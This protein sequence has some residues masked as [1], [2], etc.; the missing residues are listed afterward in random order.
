M[1]AADV[2]NP[3]I[4]P[5]RESVRRIPA[6]LVLAIGVA[7]GVADVWLVLQLWRMVSPP[8][9]AATAG[10]GAW[11]QLISAALFNLAV[12]APL[13]VAAKIGCLVEG[14]RL[15][16]GGGRPAVY[17]GLGLL[18]GAGGFSVA[19][20]LAALAGVVVRGHDSTNGAQAL[21]A[22]TG[23]VLVLGF[24]TVAEEV[25]FRGWLQ[26]VL[27]ARWGAWP[28]L[29]AGAL[30][31]SA[32]HLV[33]GVRSPIAMANLFLGGIL[34]GLLALRSGGLWA[35][36]LAHFGWN[37]LEACGLGLEPN[38]GVGQTGALIN[39]DLAG[40]RLWSGG[41]D[42]MNGSVAAL[43]VLAALVLGLLVLPPIRTA[44]PEARR[45]GSAP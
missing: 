9:A 21:I 32:L 26:P 45:S 25:Y 24:Q 16:A 39:L 28:G 34:F 40:P 7:F 23:G 10:L 1:Y 20:G 8:V 27:C 38:P 29:V 2:A 41:P 22:V 14:R 15:W 18:L 19:L 12:F 11:G 17:G 4:A 13:L 44:A 6:W 3:S 35:P 43:L 30:A 37:W 42:D 31:F 36:I 33:S 5:A